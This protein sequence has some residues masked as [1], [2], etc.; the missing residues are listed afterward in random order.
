MDTKYTWIKILR[1]LT[2]EFIMSTVHPILDRSITIE[3]Y[4][5]SDKKLY[6]LYNKKKYT[7]KEFWSKVADSEK[8]CIYIL[9]QFKFQYPDLYKRANSISKDWKET[10]LKVVNNHMRI[11]DQKLDVFIRSSGDVIFNLEL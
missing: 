5:A 8:V 2:E 10:F 7:F 3:F 4:I 6:I 9:Q 11:K 1:F